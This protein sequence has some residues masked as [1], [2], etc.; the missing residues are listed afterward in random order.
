LCRI[1][2]KEKLTIIHIISFILTVTGIVFISRPTFLFSRYQRQ[3]NLTFNSSLNYEKNKTELNIFNEELRRYIGV[4]IV[5]LTAVTV[6]V[7]TL[8]FK[9]LA[10]ARIHY[11]VINMFPGKV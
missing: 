3:L 7:I 8:I 9:K 1:F 2:L 6:G 4:G 11:A 5:L 10:N